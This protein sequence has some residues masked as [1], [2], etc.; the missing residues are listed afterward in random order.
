MVE[1][2]SMYRTRKSLIKRHRT[3][4]GCQPDRVAV[5]RKKQP[6]L[7]GGCFN[8]KCKEKETNIAWSRRYFHPYNNG[9]KIFSSCLE[10][11]LAT[12]LGST[13]RRRQYRCKQLRLWHS[14]IWS[15]WRIVPPF[16]KEFYPTYA[17]V[18]SIVIRHH[19]MTNWTLSHS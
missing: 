15:V 3:V 16:N 4:R 2:G 12:L 7:T 18:C 11:Y 8:C 17:M 10:M 13:F 19:R 14:H 9:C 6:L 1:Q 5:I